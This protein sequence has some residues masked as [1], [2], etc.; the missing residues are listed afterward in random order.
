[1]Q[2][3]NLTLGA[4]LLLLGE[5]PTN[6]R[7]VWWIYFHQSFQKTNNFTYLDEHVLLL[8]CISFHISHN[9]LGYLKNSATPCKTRMNTFCAFT[10]R[11]TRKKKCCHKSLDYPPLIFSDIYKYGI[12]LKVRYLTLKLTNPLNI[13]IFV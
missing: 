13:F 8:P 7:H 9:R 2:H 4:F 5:S 1:M 10:C 12:M 11:P 3:L 6:S